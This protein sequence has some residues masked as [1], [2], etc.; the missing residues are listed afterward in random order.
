[1]RTKILSVITCILLLC[2]II[3]INA[4]PSTASETHIT[5]KIDAFIANGFAPGVVVVIPS[6]DKDKPTVI[7]R[8]LASLELKVPMQES[9]IFRF[10]SL[11]KLVTAMR[12]KDYIASGKL[13]LDADIRNVIP[14][15]KD[16]TQP[17]TIE[18]LLTHSSGL[19][20]FFGMSEIIANV[21]KAWTREELLQ[22][23]AKYPLQFEPGT[24]QEY[25]NTGYYLLGIILE[26]CGQSL[27]KF[28]KDVVKTPLE[29][30]LVS[31]TMIVPQ[32]SSGY[33]M[34]SPHGVILPPFITSNL[35]F[36][37]GD[38]QGTVEDM[39]S[40]ISLWVDYDLIPEEYLANYGEK[41]K[42]K[43]TSAPYFESQWGFFEGMELYTFSNGRTLLGKGGM[44]PGYAAY[45]FY[46]P[47]SQKSLIIAVNQDATSKE[48]WDL[49]LD[50]L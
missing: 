30:N 7:A 32:K 6:N 48:L 4:S 3:P 14:E 24:K 19:A 10:G 41:L 35:A 21:G 43:T 23:I 27:E 29:V 15:L 16:L 31:D 11:T 50:L 45:Y 12:I 46:D 20:N 25:S 28:I 26:D 38:I 44:Y 42:Q 39:L 22:L 34:R 49:A 5:K 33:T 8:G 17:I 18:Q 9:M 40:L 47:K 36:G 2:A 37:S 1:M 13:S